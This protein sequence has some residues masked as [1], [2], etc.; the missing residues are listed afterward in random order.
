M[1]SW[2]SSNRFGAD[3]PSDPSRTGTTR[4]PEVHLDPRTFFGT[5]PRFLLEQFIDGDPL[6]L[7][8]RC[9]LRRDET[10]YLISPTRLRLKSAARCAHSGFR[11]DGKPPIEKWLAGCIEQSIRDILEEDESGDRKG[12]LVEDATHYELLSEEIGFTPE[13]SRAAHVAFNALPDEPRAAY[14]ALS[15]HGR[16]IDEFA[17]MGGGPPEL[18]RSNVSKAVSTL[19]Q[20]LPT[21]PAGEH[22]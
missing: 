19:I 14:F 20:F 22:N 9:Q 5:I 6:D 7:V 2:E 1:T 15:I 4:K 18:I 11:Y 10:A 21:P 17:A 13:A 8:L 3:G 12:A 16:S